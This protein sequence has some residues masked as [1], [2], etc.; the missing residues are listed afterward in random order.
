LML[1]SEDEAIKVYQETYG[2]AA[3]PI[4]GNPE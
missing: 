2:T 3:G 1:P 4:K